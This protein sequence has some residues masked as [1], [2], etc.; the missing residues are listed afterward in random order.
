MCVISGEVNE[1]SKTKIACFSIG[2]SLDANTQVTPAQLVVYSAHVDSIPP[3]NAFILPVYNPG[4]DVNNIIPLDLSG[5]GNFFDVVKE[6]FTHW[7]P[8]YLSKSF[9]YLGNAAGPKDVLPVHKVGDYS[10]SL[11]PHKRDF[12]RL[13]KNV[14]NVNVSALASI[15]VHNDDYSFVVYQFTGTGKLDVTPFGYICPTQKE[16]LVLPTIHGHPE[17]MSKS[18]YYRYG[19]FIPELDPSIFHNTADFDHTIYATVRDLSENPKKH[20]VEVLKSLNRLLKSVNRDYVGRNVT[21]H[22]PNNFVPHKI[23]I[24]GEKLN[25][26]LLITRETHRFLEDIIKTESQTAGYP[27]AFNTAATTTAAI[28][29]DDLTTPRPMSSRTKRSSDRYENSDRFWDNH[30]QQ[31]PLIHS[32]MRPLY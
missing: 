25:R 3:K 10:F 6:I 31:V 5:H 22:I 28:D 20:D 18:P 17:D 29:Y 16:Q 26:N 23:E 12:H 32:S 13:D 14:L 19:R 4:N 27:S 9:S 1:V 7:Y 15:D 8:Q 11:M 24:K 2:Y 21:I 30:D